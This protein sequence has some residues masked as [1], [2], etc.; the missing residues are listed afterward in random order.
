MKNFKSTVRYTSKE[1]LVADVEKAGRLKCIHHRV[2]WFLTVIVINTHGR[3]LYHGNYLYLFPNLLNTSEN[4]DDGNGQM[5][6]VF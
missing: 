4:I 1:G 5:F 2:N 6:F 3:P